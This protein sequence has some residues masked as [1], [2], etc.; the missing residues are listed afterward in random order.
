MNV[1]RWAFSLLA[2]GLALAAGLAPMNARFIERWYS[3]GVYPVIERG[4]TP[5][6][7]LV[8]FAFLD[9]LAVGGV[10]LVLLVLIRSV[11]MARRKK[12][13]SLLL[14]TLARLDTVVRDGTLV[15]A[16]A[17]AS[18]P[19]LLRST[20]ELGLAGLEVLTGIPA[21]VGGAVAMNAGT[22]STVTRMPLA[23]PIAVPSSMQS[24]TAP[25][26]PR[27]SELEANSRANT[28]ATRP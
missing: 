19:S 7:N 16:G 22:L 8:P 21:V 13:W 25:A 12:Q 2:V 6:S 17:G 20:R 23:S 18:L 1:M 11:R 27:S 5:V 4:L 24:R 14:M 10:C 26:T 28:T 9:I 15:T 3:T